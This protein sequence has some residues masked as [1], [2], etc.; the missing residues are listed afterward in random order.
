MILNL[1]WSP[2]CFTFQGFTWRSKPGITF[3]WNRSIMT[4]PETR[5]VPCQ[6]YCHC[7]TGA[8]SELLPLRSNVYISTYPFRGCT[9]VFKQFAFRK[10]MRSC[11]KRFFLRVS[12]SS[13]ILAQSF[14]TAVNYISW[15]RFLFFWFFPL[16]ACCSSI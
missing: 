8:Q 13:E 4:N 11:D 10:L 3:T 7:K 9:T 12:L 15:F 1:Y 6:N 2:N 14:I 5:L 16:S